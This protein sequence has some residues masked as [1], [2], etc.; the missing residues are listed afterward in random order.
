M[1]KLKIK[2]KKM[3]V[4]GGNITL[5]IGPMFSGKSTYLL[6]YVRKLSYTGAKT[7]FVNHSIDNR[8]TSNG[9]ICTHEQETVN[10][11]SCN[12]LGEK[13]EELEKYDI[14]GIDEGQFFS[15]L[16][17]VSEKLCLQGKTVAV[18]ALSG[19]F[20]MKPFPNIAELLSKANKIKLMKAF[21]FYCHKEAAF[22][23]RTVKS[24]KKI[25]VGSAESYK[26]VCR[27]CYYKYN[28]SETV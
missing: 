19:D 5:I 16:V 24:E 21:C 28:Q 15:D 13:M 18:A 25:L 10:A 1:S 27:N 23:L 4:E 11:I 20:R 2:N 8:Y 3:Q 22:S 6:N 17:D 26:P 9:S 12:T 14:I 7:V